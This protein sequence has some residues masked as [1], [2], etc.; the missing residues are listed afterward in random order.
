MKKVMKTLLTHLT[1][2]AL[3]TAAE[4]AVLFGLPALAEHHPLAL[5]GISL[6]VLILTVYATH[7]PAA[8]PK[9]V[10]RHATTH[11]KAA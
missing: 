7:K 8:K 11:H 1:R 9:A 4:C 5:L 3:F 10:K 6:S 2:F